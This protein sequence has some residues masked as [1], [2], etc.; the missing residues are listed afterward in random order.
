MGAAQ[1]SDAEYCCSTFVLDL[2]PAME[3]RR[4]SDADMR[5]DGLTKQRIQ[6]I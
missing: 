4:I 5:Y 6:R 3:M 2:I 1:G